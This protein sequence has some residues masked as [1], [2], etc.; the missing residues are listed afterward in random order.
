MGPNSTKKN[1]QIS[2]KKNINKTNINK[3]IEN[4]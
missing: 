2:S 4:N 3:Y 1:P